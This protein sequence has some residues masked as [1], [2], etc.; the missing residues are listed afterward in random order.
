MIFV[1]KKNKIKEE[2][3]DICTE[4]FML[5]GSR[6]FVFISHIRRINLSDPQRIDLLR[7]SFSAASSNQPLRFLPA[8]AISY[9]PVSRW[10]PASLPVC[11]LHRWTCSSQVSK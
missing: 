4:I 8:Q 5:H 9:R 11:S 2:C 6:T 3:D 7:N 1:A 10:Y